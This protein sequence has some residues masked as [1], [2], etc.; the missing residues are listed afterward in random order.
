[1]NHGMVHDNQPFV[2]HAYKKNPVIILA[3][4]LMLSALPC[5]M[6]THNLPDMYAHRPLALAYISGKSLVPMLQLQ[7]NAAEEFYKSELFHGMLHQKV[8]T[9]L[10]QITSF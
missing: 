10:Q 2:K 1:M 7:N 9:S 8:H 3:S 6:G 4:A 5:N